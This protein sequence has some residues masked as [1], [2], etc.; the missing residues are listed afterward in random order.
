MGGVVG[1]VI[2]GAR[3]SNVNAQVERAT[4]ASPS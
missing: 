4:D 3:E 2:G 1:P